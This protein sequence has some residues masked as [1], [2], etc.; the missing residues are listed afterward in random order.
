M[1]ITPLLMRPYF[2]DNVWGGERLKNDFGKDT[3]FDI[4]GESWEASAIPGCESVVEGGELAGKTLTEACAVLGKRLTGRA[5]GFPLLVKLIDAR[6]RLSVQVHPGDRYAKARHGKKGKTEAWV[7]LDAPEGASL[8]LG[9]D[10]TL[11]GFEKAISGG[12]V[13]QTL[14]HAPV[15]AGDAFNIPAGTVH[16]IGA[17]LLIYEIQQPSD[18]TYRV[19]DWGR[20]REL[21]IA[22]ALK[23][24]KAG[25]GREGAVAPA[26]ETLA[27]GVRESLV[28]NRFFALDRVSAEARLTLH[29]GGE[30]VGVLTA[31][32]E[33][34]LE[35]E[36]GALCL[37]RGRTAVLPAA[38]G[39]FALAGRG[40][41]LLG[42][43][44]GS[45]ERG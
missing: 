1:K 25:L 20:P 31:L 29:L 44:A 38:L 11:K 40:Q 27:G 37:A 43:A 23:V 4:T 6:E 10:A 39:E 3:P 41:A 42:Y 13:E 34:S 32:D 33:M 16:A 18:V 28:R 36:G 2:T 12:T 8:V 30:S 19:Y 17:G 24:I 14:R 9:I 45:G 26:R 22:D 5:K 7:V 21:H 15:K 35:Y